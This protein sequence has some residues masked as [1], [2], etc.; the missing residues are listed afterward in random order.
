MGKRG[1]KRKAPSLAVDDLELTLSDLDEDRSPAHF[2]VDKLSAD[3]RHITRDEH[4]I[5]VDNG[6]DKRPEQSVSDHEYFIPEFI[7]LDA[8]E[9]QPEKKSFGDQPSRK[10]R[11]ISSVRQSGRLLLGVL[12]IYRPYR[13][14]L[15]VEELVSSARRVFGRDVALGR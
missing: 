8:E 7:D 3:R 10:R 5:Q 13:T 12:L 1:L 11:Y 2:I 6:K 15:T 9:F 14:G 4:T